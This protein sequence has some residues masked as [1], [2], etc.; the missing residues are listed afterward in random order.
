METAGNRRQLPEAVGNS[1]EPPETAKHGIAMHQT[2]G[3]WSAGN[4]K[5]CYS[6]CKQYQNIQTYTRDSSMAGDERG[7]GL[8]NSS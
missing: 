3:T 5:L 2:R 7:G 6:K 4:T 8:V 1:R